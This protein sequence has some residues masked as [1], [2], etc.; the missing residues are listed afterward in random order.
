M[1][2]Y[3]AAAWATLKDVPNI[4]GILITGLTAL[5]AASVAMLAAVIAALVSLRNTRKTLDHAKETLDVTRASSA[6]TASTFIADKRQKWIDELRSDMA[7]HL[8]ES[9]EYV[10]RWLGLRTHTEEIMRDCSIAEDQRL[11]AATLYRHE[12]SKNNGALDRSHQERHHRLRFRLNP[13][14]PAH[15]QLRANLDAFRKLFTDVAKGA[16]REPD[17]VLI[18]RAEDLVAQTDKLT[19]EILKTEWERVKQEVAYPD[20]MIAKIPPPA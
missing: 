19:N 12:F 8:A 13:A 6:R 11:A 20:K 5:I 4:V 2:Q 18:Q 15:L 7:A 10:W 16:D 3:L 9:Q 1:T 14:E 17:N